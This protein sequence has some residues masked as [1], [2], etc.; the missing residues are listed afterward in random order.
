MLKWDPIDGPVRVNE[1]EAR[2]VL[3]YCRDQAGLDL[4]LAPNMWRQVGQ[5]I[6]GQIGDTDPCVLFGEFGSYRG[7]ARITVEFSEHKAAHS[8]LFDG[9][10]AGL[11]TAGE[12]TSWLMVCYEAMRDRGH[13]P[14]NLPLEQLLADE[15]V[16]IQYG[17]IQPPCPA[18]IQ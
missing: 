11:H 1:N 9:W 3:I 18:S 7:R 17:E 6:V 10:R 14:V 16:F 13:W 15:E 8:E 12:C 4:R 5:C 2:P